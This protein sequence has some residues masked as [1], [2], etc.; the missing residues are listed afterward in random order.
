MSK[1]LKPLRRFFSHSG[2]YNPNLYKTHYVPRNYPKD[3]EIDSTLKAIYSI[4]STPMRNMRHVNPI[5]QS[6]PLPPYDGP[7]TMED[8]RNVYFNSHVGKDFNYCSTDPEE[9]MR[10]VPGI[11]RAEAEH[12]TRLGLTPEEALRRTDALL[13]LGAVAP[14]S[15]ER[16]THSGFVTQQQLFARA[17]R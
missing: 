8:V 3:A 17:R 2:P 13:D 11:T 5:R 10:R 9:I 4:P 1:S 15:D 16:E 7:F 14:R 6:G 12:I